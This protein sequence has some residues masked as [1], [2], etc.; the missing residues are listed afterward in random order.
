M[1]NTDAMNTDQQF[2]VTLPRAMAEAVR[3]K[4]ASGEYATESEVAVAGLRLLLDRESAFDDWL[5]TDVAAAYDKLK[6]DPSR[7]VGAD[8]VR[9]RLA[10]R[11]KRIQVRL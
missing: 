8:V 9:S 11:R 5:R 3:A 2:R 10:G 7:A 1:N 6:S 4:V